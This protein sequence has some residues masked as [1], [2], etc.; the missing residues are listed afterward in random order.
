MNIHDSMGKSI[1]NDTNPY[2]VLRLLNNPFLMSATILLVEDELDAA[3][4]LATFLEINDF[5]VV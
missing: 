3:E 5:K 1:V 4:M 2:I